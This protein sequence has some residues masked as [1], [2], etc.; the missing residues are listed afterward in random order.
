MEI[1]KVDQNDLKILRELDL[2]ARASYS[3]IA[4]KT[5][6]SNQ[7]VRY[8]FERL[9]KT[10]VL[11]D[12]LTFLDTEKVGYKFHNVYLKLKHMTLEQEKEIMEKLKKIPNVAWLISTTG[13]YNL[14]VCS[15]AKDVNEFNLIW[16]SIIGIVEDWIVDHDVFIVIDAMQ[17]P[18]P[19][20]SV[21][22]R[23]INEPTP[24]IT[25]SKTIELKPIHR[26]ILKEL[27]TNSRITNKELA[28][29]LEQPESVIAYH[30]DRLLKEKIVDF[31]P[32]IDMTKLGYQWHLVLFKLK[33]VSQK[34]KLKFM[35]LL[36][37]MPQTFFIVNGVGNWNMQAEF[38]T[39]DDHEFRE[40]MHK[41]Y[42]DKFS[43]IVKAEIP[44][45]ILEEHKC[46]HYPL[47][48][49]GESQVS[50][51]RFYAK[52]KRAKQM[53]IFEVE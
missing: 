26:Q 19:L 51:D 44:L 3:A 11:K 13:E 33:Y 9:V 20:L 31:K 12:F 38:Y 2:N 52:P 24:K 1:A 47:G 49:V 16:N 53:K 17:L 25:N 21:K 6:L 8:R 42:P 4:R 45:K 10:G 14:V 29:K 32:L 15:L 43:N 50:L 30:L 7:V 48:L 37:S 34:E 36:K 5:G 22:T 35:E 41:I 39:K 46:F 23:A 18:Y 40:V 27:A 28:E